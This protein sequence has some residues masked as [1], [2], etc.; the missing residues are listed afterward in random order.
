MNILF[1]IAGYGTRFKQKGF[2]DLKPFVKIKGKYIIEY[3]LSSLKLKGNYYIITRLLEQHYIDILKNIEAKYNLK[4]NIIDVGRDTS[5]QAET[6]Y[7][8]TE[9]INLSEPLIITN[10]DQ[11][12]PWNEHK[13]LNFIKSNNYDGVVSTYKH[14]D[15]IINQ[16]GK[17]SYIKL[18][19]N[20]IAIELKEKFAISE[21]ALNGIF[22]WKTG[23]LFKQSA[24]ELLNDTSI[25]G[26]RYVSLTYN[27]LINKNYR[28]TN[29]LME[30][31]E[32]VSLGSPEEV[33]MNI[34]KL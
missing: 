3:A 31:E 27:Y 22:Y 7:L 4:L 24:Q 34:N 30:Q 5:G 29:Y 20:N 13:F 14:N 1:P 8:V 2:L 26:E 12:T 25:D 11:Y 9:Q 21:N 18:N 23:E 28:V 15:I 16:P 10:C 33:D 19:E 6:C 32:F 17:Y